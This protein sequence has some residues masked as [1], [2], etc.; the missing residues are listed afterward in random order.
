VAT[1]TSSHNSLVKR[2]RRL[3]DSPRERRKDGVAILDGVHLLDAY[4]AR[5]GLKDA[6][7]LLSEGHAAQ[8]AKQVLQMYQPGRLVQVP[9]A[10][11]RSL[12]PLET[13]TGVM[14]VVPIP[15]V[16]PASGT[17][18]FWIMLDGVQDPGNMGSILRTAAAS[19]A[20]RAVLSPACADPWSP[21][22]LRGG[23]G[24][25]F[26]LPIEDHANLLQTL[27]SFE[28]RVYAT[29]ARGGTLLYEAD[30]SRDVAI[31]LGAEGAGLAPEMVAQADAVLRIPIAEGVESLNVAAAAAM[32]C[33]ERI[34]QQQLRGT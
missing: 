5:F 31:L 10:V 1:I 15:A 20:T 21:K 34:R 2:L 12:S 23:M 11:I 16:K 9:E 18:Q 4:A 25:Q 30:L 7:V 17:T 19:G 13:P 24:A 33:G 22:C 26:A 27:E 3:I 28:G 29:D 32:I 14:A 6:I 8:E